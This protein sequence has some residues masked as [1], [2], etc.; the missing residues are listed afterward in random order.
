MAQTQEQTL[1]FSEK[2]R[3]IKEKV[4]REGIESAKE[5]LKELINEV[6]EILEEIDRERVSVEFLKNKIVVSKN[7][8]TEI[9]VLEKD[10]EISEEVL[11][12]M[13]KEL[14]MNY[15]R[16]K[17][18]TEILTLI[19]F[20]QDNKYVDMTVSAYLLLIDFRKIYL[21]YYEYEIRSGREYYIPRE[22]LSEFLQNFGIIVI[23]ETLRV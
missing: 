2:V 18:T 14:W 3:A 4:E 20:S 21:D 22:K 5:E 23:D 15:V 11:T 16:E 10:L 9:F 7:Y 17:L 19:S 13:V 6:S 1:T 12:K 8:R